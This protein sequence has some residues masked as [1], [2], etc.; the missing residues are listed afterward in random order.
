ME[1][2]KGIVEESK[3]IIDNQGEDSLK[4]LA[5]IMDYEWEEEIVYK[6]KPTILPFS[7]Y[8]K[9]VFYFSILSEIKQGKRQKS[10][11]EIALHEISHFIFLEQLS[12][13]NKELN[14]YS[15][16]YL[17]ESITTAILNRK[18]F[19]LPERR[20]NPE[21]RYINV[22]SQGE[23]YKL[24]DFVSKE[25]KQKGYEKALEYLVNVFKDKEEVFDEKMKLWN[26]YGKGITKKEK[27]FEEYKAPVNLEK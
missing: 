9:N 15:K 14:G 20:G 2:I 24:V 21:I 26:K 10:I 11:L 19:N 17:K 27:V 5:K 16:Y 7:P 18:E 1:K 6:A 4:I 3:S 23:N 12:E 22:S 13:L 25:I 8:G